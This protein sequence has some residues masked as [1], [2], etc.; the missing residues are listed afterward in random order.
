MPRCNVPVMVVAKWDVTAMMLDGSELNGMM[1]TLFAD[2]PAAAEV[3]FHG[4]PVNARKDVDRL[5]RALFQAEVV[6]GDE[7]IN[8]CRKPRPGDAVYVFQQANIDALQGIVPQVAS[9][10][11]QP[12]PTP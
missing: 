3:V 6:D 11:P 9:S 12:E 8:I 7:A 1:P 4:D 5:N 2:N 10:A